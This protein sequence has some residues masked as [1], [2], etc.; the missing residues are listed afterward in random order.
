MP[1]VGI[2][3]AGEIDSPVASAV[4]GTC[5]TAAGTAQ[6]EVTLP[7]VDA[8]FTGLTIFV[9]FT[10]SNTAVSPTLKVAGLS[11][12]PLYRTGV[13]SPGV[14]PET[15]WAAGAILPLTF[16][17][18]AWLIAGWLNTNTTYNNATPS[19]PGLMSGTDKAKLDAVSFADS[20]L[21]QSVAVA[22]GAWVSDATYPSYPYKAVISLTGVTADYFPQVAFSFGQ[23]ESYFPAS[24]AETGTGTVTVW[25]RKRPTEAITIPAILCTRQA[26][27]VT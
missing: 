5:A 25:V 24:V 13:Q 22:P 15:S 12:Y 8:V 2:V 20:L 27:G 18:T 4:Y 14:T 17:G 6:K 1:F 21:F 9:K 26:T 7:D 11:A 23:I 10:N 3:R 16:D 19:V